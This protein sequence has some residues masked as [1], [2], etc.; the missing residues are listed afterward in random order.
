MTNT[1]TPCGQIVK[2]YDPDR[3]LLSLFAP[4]ETRENLWGVMAFN[5]EIAKTREIVTETQLGHMRLQWWRE[6]I[7]KIYTNTAYEP[8]DILSA[9]ETA[10]KA[11]ALPQDLF[12]RLLY[13]REFDLEDVVPQT[14]EGVLNYADF[15]STPL[16]TLMGMIAG[17]D[18]TYEP[19]YP[20]AINYALCGIIRAVPFHAAQKRCYLPQDLLELH[21]VSLKALYKGTPEKGL[22]NLIKD[23]DAH[24]LDN[25]QP[26]HRFLKA[27]YALTQLYKKRI[28][29]AKYVPFHTK[30][31]K[32]LPFK[33]LRLTYKTYMF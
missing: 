5:H 12:E 20:I 25:I 22:Q 15:T 17:V 3:F 13:G 24:I 1:L 23:L 9:L 8:H 28:R 18:T 30:L 32:P 31:Q 19:L 11:C 10:I 16:L 29:R 2:R 33:A 6:E 14:L 21:N 26:E 27:V 7:H 4:P